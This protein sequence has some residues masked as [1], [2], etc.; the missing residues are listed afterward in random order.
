MSEKVSYSARRRQR[1]KRLGFPDFGS[2][3]LRI[4]AVVT[5]LALGASLIGGIALTAA[6]V[7]PAVAAPGTPG[8][9]QAGSLI[10]SEDFQ[11]APVAGATTVTAYT[12]ATGAKYTASAIYQNVGACNGLIFGHQASDATLNAAG[13]CTGAA[14]WFPS[15][16]TIPQAIGMYNGMTNPSTNLA[17]AEQTSGVVVANYAGTMLQRSGIPVSTTG[18]RFVTFAMDVGN[19]CSVGTVQALDRFYLLDGANAIALNSADY[20]ICAD[21]N[22]KAFAVDGQTVTVGTFTGNQANLVTSS[23]IGFRVDNTQSNGNGNDQAFDNFRI[24]DVTPQLDKVF[25]PATIEVNGTS[26][27][28]FTVTNTTELAAKN[29]WSFTDT[30][31]S[32]VT[33]A[34]VPA[35]TTTCPAGVVT[36]AAGA[37]SVKVTGNL[38]AGM[39]SC[40]VSV[41]VTSG[42]PGTY[43]NGPGNVTQTGLNPPGPAP[44]TVTDPPAWTCS[45]YGYLFQNPSAGVMNI[46]QV[47]LAKD[48]PSTKVAD[49]A[50]ALNGV[51]YNVLDNYMYGTVADSSSAMYGHL[52]RVGSD[53]VMTDLGVP[54]GLA[55]PTFFNIGDIDSAGH[56]WVMVTGVSNT[57]WY[58]IDL[59]PGSPTYGS[60]IAQGVRNAPT[61]AGVG[62]GNDWSYINGKLYSIGTAAS[63]VAYLLAFDTTTHF[64]TVLGPLAGVSVT[65]VG[66]TYADSSGYLY[67]Q[68]NNSGTI[69]RVDPTTVTAIVAGHASVSLSNDGARC[70][71]AGI[72]TITVTKQVAGRVAAADQF[73][74]GLNDP[75]GTTLTNATTTGTATT[76]STTNWPVSQGATYTI[77]DGMAAG[78]PTGLNLYTAGLV[79]TDKTGATAPIG[80]TAPNWTLQVANATDYTCVVTNTPVPAQMTTS[81]TVG[82]VAKG[83]T[84]HPGDQQ[85]YTL[86]FANAGGAPA[87]V[88]YTDFIAGVLD[89]ATVSGLQTSSPLTLSSIADGQF[90]VTGTIPGNTTYT[91]TYTATVKP[92]GQRGDNNLVNYI[93]PTGTNQ[94]TSCDPTSTTCTSNPIP[95]IQS[96]KTVDPADGTAVVGQQLTYTLHFKNVGQA[97][98]DVAKDDVLA[99][100]LD[101]AT[102]TAGPTVSNPALAVTQQLP[103]R[104]KVQGTAIPANTEYTVT[105][106]VTVKPFAQQGDHILGNF[107]VA[108]GGTPPTTCEPANTQLPDCTVTLI[109]NLTIVKTATPA[110]GARPGD[111]VK[112]TVV[113]HNNGLGDYT[114]ANPAIVSDLLAGVLDDATMGTD[115]KADR[116]PA[117]T[118]TGDQIRWAGALASGQTVTI[119]Y[120]VFLNG[121][122]DGTVSNVAWAGPSPTPPACD[123]PTADGLDPATGV[124]CG[125]IENLLPKLTMTKVAD[126]TDLPTNGG[127]VNYTVTI[128][129]DGPGAYTADDK[130]VTDDLSRVLDDG[131]LSGT[132]Q[133]DVGQATVTGTTLSWNGD[134]PANGTAVIKYTVTYDANKAGG[135]HKLLN[136]ACLPVSAAADATDPCRTVQIP[137]SALQVRKSV[138]PASGSNVFAGQTVEYTLHFDNTGQAAAAVNRTDDLTGVLDDATIAQEPTSSNPALLE[139]TRNG[140]TVAVTGSVPAGESYLVTYTVVV[141]PYAQ[142]GDHRLAN[143]LDGCVAEDPTCRTENPIPHLAVTKTSNA[144]ANVKPGDVIT[145]TV[146]GTNDGAGDYTAAQPA[147]LQDNLIDVLDDATGPDQVTGGAVFDGTQLLTWT[148][149]L[150]HGDTA[151]F[152]YEVTVTNRGNH[153]LKNTAGSVCQTPLICDPPIDVITLLPHVV[154]AKDS[155]P[156]TGTALQAG[157]QVKYTLTWINDGQAAGVVDA[158]DDLSGV[159]DDATIDSATLVAPAGIDAVLGATSLRVTGPIGVNATVVVTYTATIKPDGERGDNVA[160]NVLTPDVLPYVCAD[161]DTACDPFVPPTTEHTIGELTDWKTVNP[162]SGGTVTPDQVLTY[163]LHFQNTGTADVAVNKDDVLTQ[164]LDD[165]VISADPA[166]SDAALTVTPIAAGR[167]TVSG[168]LTP[169]QTVTVTYK[170]TVEP[171]GQ[172]GDDQ[173]GNFLVSQG[174]TPPTE[175][176]PVDQAHPDC[177]VTYVSNV[178]ASKAADPKSGTHVAAGQ[179]VTYTLT[180]H[181][182]STNPKAADS[183]VHY[184]DHMAGILDDAQLTGGP[185]PSDGGISAA[186]G[187]GTIVVTGAV[188]TGKTVTVT[189]T[190]TVKDYG[191]H[192]DHVLKNVLAVTGGD[193]ICAPGSNLCTDNPIDPPAAGGTGLALTGSTLGWG[194]PLGAFLLLI[195]GGGAIW[196]GRRRKPATDTNG[197]GD[198]S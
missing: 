83:G 50:Q 23:S 103:D 143:V 127:D 91:V 161:G 28:T 31:P 47:D 198:L 53:G 145:Y 52:V 97:A 165:A 12:G 73:T 113:A 157:D 189:Y 5:S 68:D 14:S 120:S 192:G 185:T 131:A 84:V 111:T 34:A 114:A 70:A 146:T 3:R 121:N 90:T 21:P 196:I 132:P 130:P 122:G 48:A 119:T 160:K 129:N 60:V 118:L 80:G 16:R 147:I 46:Q 186:A 128:H 81:K 37:T 42:K 112:Y 139:A 43:I 102:L 110:S 58:E 183:P 135:D 56:Y 33:L 149:A 181:N 20:N 109:P 32:G 197:D 51:G 65:N 134:L 67:G 13:F 184:T 175:C 176:M 15:A 61:V 140:N 1:G 82:P 66:A 63:G 142:Q 167:F 93:V 190:V 87:P 57:P 126:T 108:P 96:W 188:A 76:A 17:L 106:T 153:A 187:G 155:D 88:D 169:D 170:A 27:L 158:R 40:T 148:G 24:L 94:P 141:N 171:D 136:I 30:L 2:W 138:N 92:D 123:P 86:T 19:L 29:G 22:R 25:N 98:G 156:A 9:P 95:E 36:A 107:L 164:V 115:L 69:Y 101:D 45:A 180:F 26:T 105:Y 152:T 8:T 168:T 174:G 116:A 55:S 6:D 74:V 7:T 71:S 144:P 75:S 62:M 195:L 193:P 39:S 77:T 124:P 49:T 191:K 85:T 78:S 38:S 89:D 117:P 59:A 54:K 100:V 79:C 179:K 72:P 182:V 162:A 150:A 18:G 41:K 177:T 166:A 104:L 137:G 99:G 194:I 10:Y 133:A 178:V 163:T 172:R 64:Q 35:P 159:L 154:P 4:G 125:R 151:T 44:L 173:L 11:N